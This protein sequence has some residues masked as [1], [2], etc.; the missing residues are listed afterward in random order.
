VHVCGG[1]AKGTR[2]SAS[3]KGKQSGEMTGS[4]GVSK[5]GGEEGKNHARE[6]RSWVGGKKKPAKRSS[7]STGKRKSHQQKGYFSLGEKGPEMK[8]G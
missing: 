6:G 4:K 7:G 8:R 2:E 5:K 3:R 1:K